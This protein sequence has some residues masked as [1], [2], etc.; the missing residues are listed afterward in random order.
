[1][2]PYAVLCD[3][4]YLACYLNTEMELPQTRDT[5]LHF[6]EQVRKAFPKMTNFY[7]RDPNEFVL[8]EDKEAGSYRWMTLESRRLGSGYLAPPNLDDCHCQNELMLDLAPHLL[9]VSP[10]DCEA[11]DVMFGFD[12]TFKGNHDEV[13]GDAF[14]R[15]TWLEGLLS[16]PNGRIVN[17]EPTVTLAMDEECRLQCRVNVVTRTNSYQV[18]TNQFSEDAISVYF[19]VRQY[20]GIGTEMSFLESYR[21]QCDIGRELVDAHVI[22]SIV[23]PLSE[24]IAAS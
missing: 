8:E 9:T 2:N 10:L 15:D 20:W 19:T 22:P 3:E 23:V 21:R 14:A 5:V 1:M 12:F 13:V 11:L 24:A 6:F 4:F 16:V 7:G 17:F 18:R